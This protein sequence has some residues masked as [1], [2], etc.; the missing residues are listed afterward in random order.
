VPTIRKTDLIQSLEETRWRIHFSTPEEIHRWI[1]DHVADASAMTFSV[2]C[3][4]V[5]KPA[6][7]IEVIPALRRKESA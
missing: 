5:A 6:L 3:A 1:L 2:P 4:G 7:Q